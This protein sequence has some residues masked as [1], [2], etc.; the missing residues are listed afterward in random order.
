M[1]T[2]SLDPLDGVDPELVTMEDVNEAEV[3]AALTSSKPLVEQRGV[4]V[5]ETLAEADIDA[6]RPFLDE[7]GSLLTE[8]NVAIMLRAIEVLKTVAEDEPTAIEPVLPDLVSIIDS[9]LAGVQLEG[10]A[11]LGMLVVDRP[12]LCSPYAHRLT[13]ALRATELEPETNFGGV[14][15][16]RV[17]RRT[18]EEHER[19]E[20]QRRISARQRL[21]NVV[22][23]IAEAEPRAMVEEVDEL[24]ALLDDDPNVTGGAIDALCAVAE[25]EPD[26]V[27]PVSDRLVACLDH[28]S[29]AVRAHAIRA[30]G[31][32][33][34]DAA[35]SDLRAVAETDPNEDVRSIAAETAD[36][37]EET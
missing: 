31:H 16:D 33:G 15:D 19:E 12:D 17:T 29:E 5:C 25:V 32:A 22:V 37:L 2:D 1:A 28:D 24:V 13:G 36:F 14:V 23:A 9:D 20:R 11:V 18:I 6:V 26:A 3:L 35:A 7:I 10:V 4:E 34:D 27:A 8:D 30:L 21:I